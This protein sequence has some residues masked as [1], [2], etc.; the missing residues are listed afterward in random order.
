MTRLTVQTVF[1]CFWYSDVWFLNVYCIVVKRD[2]VL[3]PS[4]EGAD[5]ESVSGNFVG[6]S[7]GHPLPQDVN[8]SLQNFLRPRLVIRYDECLKNSRLATQRYLSDGVVI[9]G[10]FAPANNFEP[11]PGCRFF[12]LGLAFCSLLGTFVKK[13]YSRRIFERGWKLDWVFGPRM[14]IEFTVTIQNMDSSE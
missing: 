12:E 7:V 13:K 11:E 3:I 1:K 4:W 5:V 2:W 9:A 14:V 10:N 6:Q 8:L